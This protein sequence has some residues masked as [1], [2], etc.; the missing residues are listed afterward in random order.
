M[1]DLMSK[2]GFGYMRLPKKAGGFDMEQINKMVDAFLDSG[3]VYFDTAF[4]YQGSEAAMRDSL[5]SRYPRE[6]FKI[7]SK[8][9][10]R[11]IKPSDKIDAQFITSCERL[12]VEY[13]DSYMLHGINAAIS[14]KGEEI[15]AW[16]YIKDLKAKN[17][18]RQIGFSLHAPPKDLEEILSKHPEVDFAQL[19]INYLDWENP[20]VQSRRLYETAR[21]F[22]VPIIIMEPVKGGLLASEDSPIAEFLHKENPNASIASLALRFA[23]QL[24]GV[25][26][27][28]SGM[29]AFDQ[30][31]DNIKTFKDFKPL[32]EAER[33]MA[34]KAVELINAEPRVACTGCG[35][36]AGDC[37][38]KIMIPNMIDTYNNYLIYKTTNNVEHPYRLWASNGGKAGDCTKCGLCE[39][40]CP[41]DIIVT[42]VLEKLSA[43]FD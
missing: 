38:A 28:L 40:I 27:T 6:S 43:L 1:H 33:A 21:K 30:L 4:V 2:L 14:K 16:D 35:Y 18:V 12:G 24:E 15:G 10:L 11:H 41:Q 29:S 5:V 39:D 23:A 26:M 19:Q 37:P 34:E 17:L 25:A 8:F 9:N 3:G 7:A 32:S 36:C 13:I 22:D 42:E 20:K 31:S